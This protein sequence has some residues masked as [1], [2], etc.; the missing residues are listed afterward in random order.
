MRAVVQRVKEA[1]VTVDGEVVGRIGPG[2]LVLL[3]VG[4]GDAPADADLMAEKVANLRIFADDAG[5]MNRSVLEVGGAVLVVSQFT[6]LGDARRGR[7]P[8]FVEAAPPEEAEPLYRRFVDASLLLGL[9][10]ETGVFRAAMDVALVNEGPVTILLD[11]A[12]AF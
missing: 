2:L 7:R 1:R 3:G 10:V 4:K 9:R 5:Q 12:K 11:S 8:S 6:L